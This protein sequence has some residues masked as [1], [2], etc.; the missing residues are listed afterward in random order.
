VQLSPFSAS[1]A[2]VQKD[3]GTESSEPLSATSGFVSPELF[4]LV[5]SNVPYGAFT[6]GTLAPGQRFDGKLSLS[7][8]EPLEGAKVKVSHNSWFTADI[9]PLFGGAPNVPLVGLAWGTFEVKD[10]GDKLK[11]GYEAFILGELSLDASCVNDATHSA[12][13]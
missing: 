2:I 1:G 8:W 12:C 6:P 11:A 10:K 4:G 5:A 9:I 13:S 3:A 7:S